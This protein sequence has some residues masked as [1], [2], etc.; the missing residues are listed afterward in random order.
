MENNF[1]LKVED[2]FD[3]KERGI[4]LVGRY[5]GNVR[6]GDELI[7]LTGKNIKILGIEMLRTNYA[8]N[9]DILAVLINKIKLQGYL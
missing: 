6:V 8:H 5:K 7:T 1:V 9:S 2:I 4:V 3:I